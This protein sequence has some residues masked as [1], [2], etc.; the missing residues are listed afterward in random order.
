MSRRVEHG[1]LAQA[2]RGEHGRARS[3][4]SAVTGASSTIQTPSWT[5]STQLASAS[6]ASR[7]LPAP[8]GPTSVTSRERAS[9]LADPL[10]LRRRARRSSS[11]A[12]AGCVRRARGWPCRPCSTARCAACSSG[13]RRRAELVGQPRADPLVGGERVGL[14]A[15]GGQRGDVAGGE[16]LV[17]RVLGE[18]GLELARRRCAAAERELRLGAVDQRAQALVLQLRGGRGERL[19]GEVRERGAAPQRERLAERVGGALRVAVAQ[20][21]APAPRAPRSAARRPRRPR[22]GSRRVR[23]RSRRRRPA[24]GGRGRS[25]TAARAAGRRAARRPRRRRPARRW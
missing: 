4:P 6:P 15:G 21:A 12:R 9:S 16:P 24:R 25:A 22:A 3:R 17:Q 7:V 1:A 18:R 5:R 19:A 8:P 11:P 23:A 10:D 14:P 20:R 2:E 13:R